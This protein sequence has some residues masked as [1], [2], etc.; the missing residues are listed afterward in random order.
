MVVAIVKP[1]L[2]IS[3]SFVSES[4]GPTTDVYVKFYC[5]SGMLESMTCR[6]TFGESVSMS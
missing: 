4:L 5:E 3:R 2:Q 1:H 6:K